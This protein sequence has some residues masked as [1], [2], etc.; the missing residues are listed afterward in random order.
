MRTS[1]EIH[2]HIWV[3]ADHLELVV[4]GFND[5]TSWPVSLPDHFRVVVIV[6]S[7]S[8]RDSIEFPAIEDL[9]GQDGAANTPF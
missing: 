5:Q 3:R 8:M 9:E 6:G 1:R 4:H 7:A 2:C